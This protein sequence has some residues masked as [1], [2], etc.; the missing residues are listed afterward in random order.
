MIHHHS[1]GKRRLWKRIF[2]MCIAL[3]LICGM[4]VPASSVSAS[5][6]ADDAAGSAP[7]AVYEFFVAGSQYDSQTIE[8]GGTLTEPE[9]PTMEGKVFDGWYT[10]E[11]GGEKFTDFGP[12]TVTENVTVGLYA[13][14]QT[15]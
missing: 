11:E 15:D 4:T 10:S 2:S 9:A 7:V 6:D 13:G 5:N 14:W 1:S 3:I 12:K 8:D